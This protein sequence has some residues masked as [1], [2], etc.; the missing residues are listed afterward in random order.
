MQRACQVFG[1]DSTHWK[2]SELLSLF[3]L[4]G[5]ICLKPGMV[6][7]RPDSFRQRKSWWGRPLD[8]GWQANAHS[9]S[10]VLRSGKTVCLS[11]FLGFKGRAFSRQIPTALRRVLP[12][13]S[14]A[15]LHLSTSP[16]YNLHVLTYT[17]LNLHMLTCTCGDVHILTSTSECAC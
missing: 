13:K 5:L 8:T 17:Y 6:L 3:F 2:L 16:C 10:S 9:N 12:V 7:C 14:L 15:L 4:E 11:F 1:F